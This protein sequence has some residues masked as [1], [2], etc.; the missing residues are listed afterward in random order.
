[1]GDAERLFGYPRIGKRA[2][3][4]ISDNAR[5]ERWAA[6]NAQQLGDDDDGA[7]RARAAGA[8]A[9]CAESCSAAAAPQVATACAQRSVAPC[10]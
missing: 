10:A 4:R 1:M 8:V 2:R 7:G 9:E 6:W 5:K 3:K